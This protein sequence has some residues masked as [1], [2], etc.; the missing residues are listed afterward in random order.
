MGVAI[1]HNLIIQYATHI[2]VLHMQ[3]NNAWQKILATKLHV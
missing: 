3:T 1:D 2:E